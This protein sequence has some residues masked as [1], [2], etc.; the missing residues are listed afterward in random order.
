MWVET[1]Y[2]A[3][4][5]TTVVLKGQAPSQEILDKMISVAQ[6]VEG[7]TNIDSSQVTIG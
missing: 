6:S 7:A 2:V 5:G 3:Q 1:L 4:T